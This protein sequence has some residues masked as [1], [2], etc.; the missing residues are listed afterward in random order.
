MTLLQKAVLGTPPTGV[1]GDPVRTANTK[2]NANVDVLNAQ[3][4]LTSFAAT[5]TDTT[6]LTAAHIGKRVNINVAMG[7]KVFYMPAAASGADSVIH[8]RNVGTVAVTLSV[9][10]PS[11][12][13]AVSQLNA[14]E[15]ITFDAD[16][17][18]AWGCLMRGRTNSANEVV[19]GTLLVGGDVTAPNFRGNLVQATYVFRTSTANTATSIQIS[20][21]GT[22][23]TAQINCFGTSDI[24][25]SSQLS[26]YSTGVNNII[27]STHTGTGTQLPLDIYINGAFNWRYFNNTG[28]SNSSLFASPIVGGSLHLAGPQYQLVMASTSYVSPGT[29]YWLIGPNSSNN[30]VVFNQGAQGCYIADGALAWAGQSDERLKNIRSEITGAVEAIKD[31][32]TVRYTW[33]SDDDHAEALGVENDS[34]VHVGV[35]AQDVKKHVPEAVSISHDDYLGVAYTDLVPLCMAAIKELSAQLDSANIAI[36]ALQARP[37]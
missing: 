34:R 8:L 24:N 17:I 28:Q 6:V 7:G 35:I 4:T 29:H 14:G 31:I 33:R 3:A 13:V 1:D 11:D 23:N 9:A 32:R 18:K 26:L 36:A 22:G 37:A 25:N 27:H 12:T 10:V 15:A 16:G 2:F 30:I 19:Q 20:P 21:S 5:L